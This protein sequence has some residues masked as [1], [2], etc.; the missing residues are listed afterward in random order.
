MN[1][2]YFNTH[3]SGRYLSPYGYKVPSPNI[4]AFARESILFR[5][6]FCTSPTC[7]PSRGSLLS[8][9]YA[10]SNGLIGLSHRGHEMKDYGK[11]LGAFLR[12]HGYK[13]AIA[14]TEHIANHTHF[15]QHELN[16]DVLPYDTVIGMPEED[17]DIE[18]AEKVADY[19][20]DSEE[21]DNF[22]ISFGLWSTHRKYPERITEGYEPEYIHVPPTMKDTEA[23]REDFAHYC[24]SLK[25]ADTCFQ[26]VLNALKD[27][28]IYEDT[29]VIM[30]TDHGLASPFNKACLMDAGIG[31]ALMMHIPGMD[32]DG[33]V[34]DAMVSHVDIFPTVCDILGLE[35]PDYLQG[36]SQ[37]KVLSGDAESV[38]DTV[39]AETNYHASFEPMRCIRTKDYKYIRVLHDYGKP[40]LA[41]IDDSEPKKGLIEVGFANHKVDEEYLFDLTIDPNERINFINDL[42]YMKIKDE[43]SNKL[44]H[45]L[46]KT[47]D[48]TIDEGYKHPKGIVLNAPEAVRPKDHPIIL[49]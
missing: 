11:H 5:R 23:N 19:I 13:T 6:A 48:F 22:F 40:M 7:S 36:V 4:E 32:A 28:G 2:I 24:T 26:I 34:I 14:G 12:E 38:R 20:K 43:L 37:M 27:K 33:R 17:N 1:V 18:N 46:V 21:G 41:N 10:H 47:D 8:G 29:L 35:K 39:Y 30:T 45:F 15:K 42:R 25:I 44:D 31:V 16:Y 9:M 3:D 49:K